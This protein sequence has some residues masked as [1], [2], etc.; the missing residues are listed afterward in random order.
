MSIAALWMI[1][2]EAAMCTCQNIY[3]LKKQSKQV[4]ITHTVE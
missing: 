2:I 4:F 3:L 1:Y